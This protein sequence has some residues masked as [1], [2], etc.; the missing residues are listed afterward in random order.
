M[1]TALLNRICLL[2]LFFLLSPIAEA[3]SVKSV[4]RRMEI[5]ERLWDKSAN[6]KTKEQTSKSVDSITFMMLTG[7]IGKAAQTIDTAICELQKESQGKQIPTWF[8]SLDIKVTKLH[9]NPKIESIQGIVHHSYGNRTTESQTNRIRIRWTV[10]ENEMD[11]IIV[12]LPIG[13]FRFELF[14]PNKLATARIWCEPADGE[15]HNSFVE[16]PHASILINP[17]RDSFTKL[18]LAKR[19][20]VSELPDSVGKQTWLERCEDFLSFESQ[21][22]SAP[23][24]DFINDLVKLPE[25]PLEKI[26]NGTWPDPIP[27]SDQV[28][29]FPLA[30]GNKT[31]RI[32]MPKKFSYKYESISAIVALHGAGDDENRWIDGFNHYLSDHTSKRGW[33]LICPRNGFEPDLLPSIEKWA[34]LKINKFAIIGHSQGGSQALAFGAMYP[35]KILALA[36]LGAS[37]RIGNGD[38]Y[39]KLPI[40][41]GI[42]TEDLALKP[43]ESMVQVMKDDEKEELFYHTYKNIGHVIGPMA[44]KSDLLDFLDGVFTNK[45]KNGVPKARHG[46]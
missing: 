45:H 7:Q 29:V 1:E 2:L 10:N 43:C 15:P 40:F 42:G 32:R 24:I 28:L 44:S 5:L 13:S 14:P 8:A 27:G 16:Y 25:I 36:A 26:R 9:I 23:S 20:S 17:E 38:S 46:D 11:P 21:G 34:G 31:V 12:P 4:T 35:D 3:Q 30:K 19:K 37:G 41:I 6:R 39:Q 33:F 22:K 18:M